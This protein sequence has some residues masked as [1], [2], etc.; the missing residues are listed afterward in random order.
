MSDTASTEFLLS[1]REY[2][3]LQTA[4]LITFVKVYYVVQKLGR[5]GG[6]EGRGVLFFF[7]NINYTRSVCMSIYGIRETSLLSDSTS[8]TLEND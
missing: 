1:Y 7:F 4:S 5:E 3:N 8:V 2:I 6:K